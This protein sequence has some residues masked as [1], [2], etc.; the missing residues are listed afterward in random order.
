M[1]VSGL[2]LLVIC[3]AK[4]FFYDL[5]ELETI[6]KI[7]SFIILGSLLIGVSFAYSRYRE[8]IRRLL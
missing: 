2:A 7:F 1:R 8:Q 4:V 5:N 6:F 3:V